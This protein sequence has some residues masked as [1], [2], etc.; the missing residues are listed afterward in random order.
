MQ[1][2]AFKAVALQFHVPLPLISDQRQ[3]LNNYA[4]AKLALYDDAVIP[5]AGRIFGGLSDFLL[6]RYG[7]DPSKVRITFNPETVSALV[8]RRNDELT[9]RKGLGVET[10]NELRAL[11]GRE[12]YE[13]GDTH[14]KLAAQVPVGTDLFTDDNEPDILED[15]P[16]QRGAS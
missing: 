15:A 9:K 3:T 6:P 10:D 11:L 8:S 14:Y 1:M 12:P 2:M 13:G 16:G 4:I 5:L 7:M